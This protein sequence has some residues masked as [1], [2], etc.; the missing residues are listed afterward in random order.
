VLV[1]D[2]ADP[3]GQAIFARAAL[4]ME[5]LAGAR[6]GNADADEPQ[7]ALLRESGAELLRECC[8]WH[9]GLVPVKENL[10]PLF[11]VSTVSREACGQAR[12]AALI[13]ATGARE[14]SYPRP[15]WDLPGVFGLGEAMMMLESGHAFL[16]KR[17]V[18]IGSGERARSL[19]KLVAAA[20]GKLVADIDPSHGWDAS[21]IDGSSTVE[22]VTLQRVDDGWR[23]IAQ[24]EKRTLEADAVCIGYGLAPSVEIYQLLG[25]KLGYAPE[26]GGWTPL[27]DE[28]QRTSVSRLYGAGDCAGVRGS[29]SARE[30]GRVAALSAAL[31]LGRL[32]QASYEREMSAV[33]RD[34]SRKPRETSIS[35][36]AGPRSSAMQWVPDKTVVCRCESISAGE[37][38]AAIAAGA[39]EI[40]ALKAATR[41][42]MGPCGGR[43]CEEAGAA[44]L[45]CAGLSRQTIGKLT[46]R[47]PLRP[48]SM[49][50][51]TGN[52]AYDDIPFPQ[53]ADM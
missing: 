35:L 15:G 14:W 47:A 32:D 25:A 5:A 29:A 9:V 12:S 46:A 37:L 38:R 21:S 18:V 34:Q 31:D 52:F 28:G 53:T 2:E 10:A 45:E 41:C 4:W 27:T 33:R 36:T 23:P 17:F 20:G 22:S 24:G 50:L 44:L 6:I 11:E 16:G 19:A 42:G 1:L 30:T 7:R 51:L 48:L 49:T 13:V 8:V 39:C 3:R 26:L 43:V 40:N